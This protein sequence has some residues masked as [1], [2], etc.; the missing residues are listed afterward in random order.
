LVYAS[1]VVCLLRAL[2][3]VLEFLSA[4]RPSKPAGVT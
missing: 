3:V 4:A 1:V 2:P